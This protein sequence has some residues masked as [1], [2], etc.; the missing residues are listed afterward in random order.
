M[1]DFEEGDTLRMD[2]YSDDTEAVKHF[3]ELNGIHLLKFKFPKDRYERSR[4]LYNSVPL[5][6]K[7][8]DL[9]SIVV[10]VDKFLYDTETQILTVRAEEI[11]KQMRTPAR[12]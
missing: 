8:R 6:I 9:T 2:V 1:A 10:F 7:N 5:Y 4:K 11:I 3:L 12:S